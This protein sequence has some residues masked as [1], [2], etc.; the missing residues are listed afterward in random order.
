MSDGK[1]GVSC[2]A[3]RELMIW[4]MPNTYKS[5]EVLMD[6]ETERTVTLGELTP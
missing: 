4:L 1:S 6:Y 3:C 5:A 2:G